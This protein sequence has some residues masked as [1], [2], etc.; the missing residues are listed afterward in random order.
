[1]SFLMMIILKVIFLFKVETN[2]LQ[3]KINFLPSAKR[4]DEDAEDELH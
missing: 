1:M 3:I 2:S 4:K